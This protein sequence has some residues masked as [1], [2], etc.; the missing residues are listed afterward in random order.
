MIKVRRLQNTY[1][2]E[3]VTP[4]GSAPLVLRVEI[5]SLEATPTERKNFSA[6]VFRYDTFQVSP[7][8]P[9]NFHETHADHD[10]LVLDP[11]FG[12]I[13]VVAANSDEA[14]QSV[15]KVIGDRLGAA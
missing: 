12:E 5:Y 9:Q 4:L 1:E 7:S 2:I 8:F 13:D 14:L 15:I 10:I 11:L 3:I 6:R